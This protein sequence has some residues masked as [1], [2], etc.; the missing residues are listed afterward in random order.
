ML[1]LHG[2]DAY[3][4]E[5]SKTA[6]EACESY[7]SGQLEKPG[8]NNYG[9][10]ASSAQQAGSKGAVKFVVGDFFKRDW[11]ADCGVEG[12]AKF[13]LIYDYTVGKPVEV[14]EDRFADALGV[15]PL[16]YLT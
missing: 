13:D 3:G 9:T 5:V 4:V 8:V 12:N 16:R 10:G 14:R 15:V 11:E 6:V 1:A 2:F 7:A